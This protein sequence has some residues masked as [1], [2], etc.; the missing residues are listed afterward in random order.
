MI[1]QFQFSN[2]TST[3]LVTMDLNNHYVKN[4]LNAHYTKLSIIIWQLT[5]PIP[6]RPGWQVSM[7]DLKGTF[8]DKIYMHLTVILLLSL[9]AVRLLW[10][11]ALLIVKFNGGQFIRQLIEIFKSSSLFG[12][13]LRKSLTDSIVCSMRVP[14][15]PTAAKGTLKNE[16]RDFCRHMVPLETVLIQ[17]LFIVAIKPCGFHEN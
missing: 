13:F 11:N 3:N 8:C 2:A 6:H 16:F 14:F 9:A 5:A 12:T 4:T 7:T 1:W 15:L 10:F 17:T